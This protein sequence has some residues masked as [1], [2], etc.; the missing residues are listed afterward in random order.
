MRLPGMFLEPYVDPTYPSSKSLFYSAPFVTKLCSEG[1]SWLT[2]FI[3]SSPILSYL[4]PIRYVPQTTPPKPLL[5]LP[6]ISML[7]N[8][9]FGLQTPLRELIIW[10]NWSLVFFWKHFLHLAS[11]TLPSTV[12][13][14]LTNCIV[15][16]S[17]LIPPLYSSSVPWI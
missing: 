8:S 2:G 14:P 3:S 9:M 12:F 15:P 4:S 17:L 13:S 1:L 5:R 16:I 11:G 6:M 10:C 7:L